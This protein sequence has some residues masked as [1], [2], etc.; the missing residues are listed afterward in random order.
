MGGC[1]AGGL[2]LKTRIGNCWFESENKACS[3]GIAGLRERIKPVV[4]ELLV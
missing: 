4:K 2:S 3:K 1:V